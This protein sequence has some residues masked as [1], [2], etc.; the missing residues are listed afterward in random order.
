MPT[1]DTGRSDKLTLAAREWER[2]VSKAHRLEFDAGRSYARHWPFPATFVSLAAP[3]SIDR[4]QPASLAARKFSMGAASVAKFCVL[5]VGKT[6]TDGSTGTMP[7]LPLFEACLRWLSLAAA[8]L[9]RVNTKLALGADPDIAGGWIE[10]ITIAA[11]RNSTTPS[12]H[13]ERGG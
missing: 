10:T 8:R 1:C 9:L 13:Q 12:E 4:E 5:P 3:G 6:R 11:G 2:P 7:A